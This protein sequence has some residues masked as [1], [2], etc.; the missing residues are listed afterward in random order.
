MTKKSQDSSG[1]LVLENEVS[2]LS[3]KCFW[4]YVSS[5][6][7][8][9]HGQ[10]PCLNPLFRWWVWISH[11]GLIVHLVPRL[12]E[13]FLD[14]CLIFHMI[15]AAV[16]TRKKLGENFHIFMRGKSLPNEIDVICR[17]CKVYS[18]MTKYYHSWD[19][20]GLKYL[21]STGHLNR[22]YRMYCLFKYFKTTS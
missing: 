10:Q 21:W 5:L 19:N 13:I 22:L 15:F 9:L 2:L 12:S 16:R 18:R 7:R 20:S 3:D 6:F 4:Q 8:L 17:K 1:G 14:N 11:S